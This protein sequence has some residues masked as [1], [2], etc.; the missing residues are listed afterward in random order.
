[1]NQYVT[2]GVIKRLREK[3][4]MTQSQLADKLCV[5]AKTVSK[6]ETGK[7][8]PDISLIEPLSVVLGVS[9]IELMNGEE[10][11]NRNRSGNM[12]KSGFFVCPVC[13]NVVFTLGEAVVS[14]CGIRLPVLESE[15]TDIIKT[16]QTDGEIYVELGHEMSKSHYISFMAYVCCDR[17]E[18][19]K[20]YPE[21][22]PSARFL[23]RGRG[24]IYAFC[25]RDG[26]F[27]T[28]I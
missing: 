3:N 10:V 8:L 23:R 14:C 22:E 4:S 13:G 19:V 12:R 25:N 20:L 27:K 9:V 16:T 11:T 21:Q 26:L 24:E 2:A 5:S 7:G 28:K 17:A 6:W 18:I 1:M 15:E